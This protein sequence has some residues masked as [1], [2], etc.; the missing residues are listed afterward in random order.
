MKKLF[1]ILGW[2]LAVL[3][4]L[5][6]GLILGF[7]GY[8][9]LQSSRNLSE[10]GP[11]A[12]VVTE[13]EHTFRDLNKNGQLDPY[14][15][16]RLPVEARVEN[17]LGQMTVAEKAGLMFHGMIVMKE[18]GD[19]AERPDPGNPFSF[20]IPINSE[21]VIGRSMNHFN[22][23][24]MGSPRST[25]IWHNNLQKLAG[26]TRLGIPVTISS[27]PRHGVSHNPAAAMFAAEFS[28]WPEPAG[29]A[30]TRDTALVRRFGEIARQ[31][32][33][34]V[35]IRTA[36]HPMADLATEPRWGRVNG[37]F[38]E[39]A[40]VASR[41]T[42][43]YIKGF[44][45]DTLSTES[46][47]T[48]AKHF[49]GGGPQADGEDAH[50][51][52]GQEQ[53]YPGGQFDYHLIPF[54]QGALAAHTAQIM[55]YYS[56]PV[57]QTGEEVSFAF[58]KEIIDMLRDRYGFEGVICTDW[59]VLT[60]KGPF[61]MTM[62]HAPAWGVEELS[63]EERLL[64]ALDAGVDQFGG[65]WTP[66]LVFGLVE[67]GQLPEN[68]LDDS[69]RRIL[70]DKFTLGLFD[71]PYID[72]DAAEEIVGRADFREAGRLAQRKSIVLLKNAEVG[73]MASLPLS[74]KPDLYIEN[75]DPAAVSNYG[76]VVSTPDSA[77]YAILRLSAP[78]EPRSG[79]MLESFF[80]QGD[81]DFKAR[82]R[83]HSRRARYR[84]RHRGYIHGPAG[85]HSRNCRTERRLAGQLRRRRRCR[86]GRDF[87]TFQPHGEIA[88]RDAFVHGSCAQP[89]G[90]RALRLRK[91]AFPRSGT[92]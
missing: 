38:G 7:R 37:T 27:D 8:Y 73:G 17:L 28:R 91:S 83:A 66:D 46:V 16:S 25:A 92:G 24:Q 2:I 44:Q 84:T 50:F 42:Y 57:G 6:V 62:I 1:K 78:Y 59:S 55:P 75:M 21:L 61:G 22:L 30:A 23:M 45:G 11:E 33:R 82:K 52:Y 72:P 67:T 81:L 49:P 43:A 64:K 26:R 76:D 32:Y 69:A 3:L 29:L 87:R 19:L 60:D 4:L 48:M 89:A 65:E 40:G 34:A 39:D 53:V 35:G 9:S 20:M 85:C 36:L 71:D 88:L 18:N 31:E 56:I 51:D 5:V 68:R 86:T 14:E 74:G 41:M 13:A 70:R 58:N 79:S 47:A 77:D 10:A 90:R 80:H 63:P 15:D 54:E 12:P